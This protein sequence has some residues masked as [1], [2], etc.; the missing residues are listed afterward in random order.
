VVYGTQRK[1]VNVLV[2]ESIW[3]LL[4]EE[5]K[6][7]GFIVLSFVLIVTGIILDHYFS[8]GINRR[9]KKDGKF[10]N[11]DKNKV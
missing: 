4:T 6:I 1:S 7:K 2:T 9:K 11:R 3:E 8:Q 10:R 5:F